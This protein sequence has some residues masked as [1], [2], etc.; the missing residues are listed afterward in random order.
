MEQGSG[1][2]RIVGSYPT[3]SQ[4]NFVFVFFSLFLLICG[5]L[6]TKP[7][8]LP[9]FFLIDFTKLIFLY[10]FGYTKIPLSNAA[11]FRGIKLQQKSNPRIQCQLSVESA[12]EI[13]RICHRNP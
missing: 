12:A 7:P 10:T 6:Q 8:P 1:E 13:H 5:A 3:N 4:K 2:L 11:T 9:P